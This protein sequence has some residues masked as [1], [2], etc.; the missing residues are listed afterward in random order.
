T[1]RAPHKTRIP[2]PRHTPNKFPRHTIVGGRIHG[3][4][5]FQS[6]VRQIL[7]VLSDK[8]PAGL[9]QERALSL[10][11]PKEFVSKITAEH[12]AADNDSVEGGICHCFLPRVANV[13]RYG[14]ETER[15]LLIIHLISWGRDQ[16]G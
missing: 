16:T 1:I 6:D 4:R 7:E 12:T 3:L 13:S 9:E 11:I 10:R 5:H 8:K 15:G 2:S 14:V